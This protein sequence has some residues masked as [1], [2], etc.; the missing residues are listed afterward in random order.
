MLGDDLAI[1]ASVHAHGVATEQRAPA[2]GLVVEGGTARL[3][4]SGHGGAELER[5]HDA[6]DYRARHQALERALARRH[7]PSAPASPTVG[8]RPVADPPEEPWPSSLWTESLEPSEVL[9]L[10]G[11]LAL[12]P[13]GLRLEVGGGCA[14]LEVTGRLRELVVRLGG[15]LEFLVQ[16]GKIAL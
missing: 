12:E 2:T 7:A 5:A 16:A 13:S 15:L 3:N 1:V 6:Q 9:T 8:S 10:G 4:P 14:A 11:D